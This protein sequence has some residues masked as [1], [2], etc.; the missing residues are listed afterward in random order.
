[1][2]NSIELQ[3]ITVGHMADSDNYNFPKNSTQTQTASVELALDPD[4][5]LLQTLIGIGIGVPQGTDLKGMLVEIPLFSS[6]QE[7]SYCLLNSMQMQVSADA[8]QMQRICCLVLQMQPVI[9][10]RWIISACQ[11]WY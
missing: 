5:R 7:V 4:L 1:M 10:C 11:C 2:E 8:D 6:K 9:F 3:V